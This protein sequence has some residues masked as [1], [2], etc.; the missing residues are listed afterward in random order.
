M[1]LCKHEKLR[2][3]ADVAA[4]DERLRKC[5]EAASK[6]VQ[7]IPENLHY[8]KNVGHFLVLAR[9]DGKKRFLIQPKHYQAQSRTSFQNMDF[10]NHSLQ[11]LLGSGFIPR[12][13]RVWRVNLPAQGPE[14]IEGASYT[15]QDGLR[16]V[17]PY[18]AT[19]RMIANHKTFPGVDIQFRDFIYKRF[20]MCSKQTLDAEMRSGQI[21]VNLEIK[22]PD[23]VIRKGDVMTRTVHFHEAPILDAEPRIIFEDSE[24]LVVDKPPSWPVHPCGNYRFNSL[25]YILAREYGYSDLRPIHRLDRL[26]SGTLMIAKGHLA[27]SKFS[28]MVKRKV[29]IQKE[30]LALVRGRFSQ[31]TLIHSSP[32]AVNAVCP[33]IVRDVRE[34]ECVS[35]FRFVEYY[36]SIDCTLVECQPITGRTHQLRLHLLELGHPIVNDSLY[37][38]NNNSRQIHYQHHHIQQQQRNHQ[39][40]HRNRQQQQHPEK[41]SQEILERNFSLFDFCP[42]C[43]KPDLDRGHP[44]FICLHSLRYKLGD[45]EFTSD[46]PT[47]IPQ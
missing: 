25:L 27:C 16:K 22:D 47:W 18:L 29:E 12:E 7:F 15:F 37:D 14:H 2:K 26:T 43:S 3:L 24:L 34:K 41:E 39:H 20:S 13:E 30:Y 11:R 32:I 35:Q 5:A 38:T 28:K 1:K 17:D 46:K 40:N 23:Y 33:E 21:G 6:H 42:K 4:R 9:S 31:T 19:F 8:A 44:D 45:L 36:P 10:E